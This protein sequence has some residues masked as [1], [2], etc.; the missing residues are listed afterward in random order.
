MSLRPAMAT[1]QA[2]AERWWHDLAQYVMCQ[3]VADATGLWPLYNGLDHGDAGR[4][5]ALAL[6][7]AEKLGI[8]DEYFAI[9][10]G[11]LAAFSKT[12]HDRLRSSALFQ[13]LLGYERARRKG[14]ADYE[15]EAGISGVACCGSMRNCPYLKTVEWPY[16]TQECDLRQHLLTTTALNLMLRR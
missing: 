8:A 3:S 5:H 12:T 16:T 10:D 4:F 13:R 2:A 9:H 11:Q 7:L 1:S 14:L 6:G 15:F